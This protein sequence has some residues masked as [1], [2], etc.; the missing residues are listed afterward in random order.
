MTFFKRLLALCALAGCSSSAVFHPAAH[1]P[2]PQVVNSGGVVLSAPK[3]TAVTFAGDPLAP[4]LER[5]LAQIGSTQY[6]STVTAEYGVHA[7]SATNPVHVSTA[8]P[9]MIDDAGIQAFI[10]KQL[11]D[12]TAAWPAADGNS[13][14]VLF[15]PSS[16]TVTEKSG[17]KLCSGSTGYHSSF[18][19]ANGQRVAYA[20]IARCIGSTHVTVDSV[21]LVTSHELMEAAT[22]PYGGTFRAPSRDS[23]AW[24]YTMNGGEIGDLCEHD[25]SSDYV[26]PE[27]GY[28]VQRG[29]SNAQAAAGHDPCV[30]RAE[31]DVYFGAAPVASDALTLRFK[32]GSSPLDTLGVQLTVGAQ[33]TIAL[34]LFSD[35]PTNPITV[36]AEEF[37]IDASVQQ[38]ADLQFSVD[39]AEGRNGDTLHLT[40]D[41]RADSYGEGHEYFVVYAQ[42]GDQQHRW[43]VVVGN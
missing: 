12:A 21:T 35:A 14:Y 27:L 5:F 1:T 22:D 4:D 38:P 29:W 33:K 32:D 18:V 24:T 15:Y 41:A 19:L 26:S 13:L 36:W 40:I 23:Y 25:A 28:V 37:P 7:G 30:P 8:A 9:A 43:P 39:K 17:K 11:G 6:W 34:Q 2:L 3:W 20:V 31:G 42:L 10:G 16:T